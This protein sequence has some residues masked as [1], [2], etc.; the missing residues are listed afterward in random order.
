MLPYFSK[1]RPNSARLFRKIELTLDRGIRL[2]K[3]YGSGYNNYVSG[4]RSPSPRE[5]A[6]NEWATVS[7]IN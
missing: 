2:G 4:V 7:A 5:N 6:R 3:N 1:T